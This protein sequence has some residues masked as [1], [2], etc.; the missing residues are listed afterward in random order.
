[1]RVRRERELAE[2]RCDVRIEFANQVR[3]LLV[4]CA[5]LVGACI[6][7][8]RGRGGSEAPRVPVGVV[9]APLWAVCVNIM[10]TECIEM[11][12]YRQLRCTV[13]WRRSVQ[14]FSACGPQPAI[15]E[16]IKYLRWRILARAA[17]MSE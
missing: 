4:R 11:L 2:D 12:V 8:S 14:V 3:L 17:V 7:A 5:Q 13:G 9:G 15:V 10:R 1:M 16:P 6:T